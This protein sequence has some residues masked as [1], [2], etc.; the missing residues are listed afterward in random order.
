MSCLFKRGVFW[1]VLALAVFATGG[2]LWLMQ[3]LEDVVQ[4]PSE[5]ILLEI[6]PGQ[7]LRSVASQLERDGQLRHGQLWWLCARLSGR[8]GR[9]QAGEYA[10]QPGLNG[11]RLL[12][13][14]ASGRVFQRQV[15]L[16]EGW[17][18]RQAL[19]HIQAQPKLRKTLDP[20]NQAAI[21]AALGGP[22][23]HPEGL[24]F[25]DTYKYA[26]GTTDV[27]VLRRAYQHMLMVLET[28]WQQRGKDLPYD[29]AY[30]ALIMASIV[31][32]E[33]GQAAERPRIAGVFVSRL[34][35]G[36]R[37]ETDPTVIY[38]LGDSYK[39]DITRAH[40]RTPSAYNTYVIKGLPP[41]PI[42]LAG[43][44]AI[45]AALHPERDGSLYFVARGDGS[46]QFSRT[47]EEHQA[48]VQKFQL[49]QRAR[50]YRSQPAEAAK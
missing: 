36:M 38:G 37:L 42:A 14:L 4:V 40:L 23:Q 29:S 5:G 3:G 22:F 33:T 19:Q 44:E 17:T 35:Q 16:V 32:K 12:D 7:G 8:A 30:Q 2:R 28:E 6:A 20:G 43:R 50:D 48:A 24:I 26:A 13:L 25:P 1:S 11:R 47:L 49:D 39:G 34:A 10:L 27:D 9:I 31:E 46:H 21:L 15:T 45:R 18:L 41:T